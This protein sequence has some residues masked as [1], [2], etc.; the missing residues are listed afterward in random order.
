[1]S[2]AGIIS[3]NSGGGVVDSITATAPLTANGASG[4]PETG[5]VTIALTT[6]LTGAYGGTG[7]ANT[8]LT[9]NLG[10]GSSGYVLTSDSSGNGTWEAASAS[11]IVT[12]DGDSDSVTGTTV[13]ITGGS[14][15]AYFTGSGSTLTE[16]FNYLALPSTTS[17]NGQIIVNG[18]AALHYYE[19]TSANTNLFL[20]FYA[21]N[22]TTT[23]GD[24]TAVGTYALNSLT[25]GGGNTAVGALS[26]QKLTS[27]VR[28]VAIGI[29]SGY[30]YTTSESDNI[31]IGYDV[32][33]TI[34]ESNILR[35]GNGTGVL[36]GEISNAYISGIRGN[37]VSNA[38]LVTVNS[39]TDQ[40]GNIATSNNGVLI[41][42]NSGVPSW[43]ANSG[44]AG[45]VLTAQ[46]GAPPQ[47]AAASGGI[48]TLVADNSGTATGSSVTISGGSTGLTTTAS[49]STM[50][51]TGVL[52]GSNGGTG[53][54]NT[55]L[56]INLGSG[57]S[58]YVLTSDSSGNGTWAPASGGGGST[59]LF[60]GYKSSNSN[61]VTGD[62]TEAYVVWDTASINTGSAYNTS[63]GVFTAPSTGLYTFSGSAAMNVGTFGGNEVIFAFEY[64]NGSINYMNLYS[65]AA[66]VQDANKDVVSPISFSV[67]MNSG[68]TIKFYAQA[69]NGSK[70]VAVLGGALTYNYMGIWKVNSSGSGGPS[71]Y[72]LAYLSSNTSGVTGTG[73]SYTIIYDTVY[74]NHGSAYNSSTGVF[75]APT[76]GLYQISGVVTPGN[77]SSSNTYVL[78]AFTDGGTLAAEFLEIAASQSLLG[79]GKLVLPFSFPLYMSSGNAINL[80]ISV[81][82]SATNNVDIYGGVPD[83]FNN[84]LTFFSAMSVGF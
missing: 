37:S 13:K 3:I 80:V 56:T 14:S 74:V 12:I 51:L 30:S 16:S 29:Q 31:L 27:G 69:V 10:S 41:T 61:N 63:T 81:G 53:V 19:S 6:P 50:D 24:T 23:T 72:F 25:S 39:S 73:N 35:I 38:T 49:S 28:N 7:V 55:G 20:G 76:T 5:A 52:V 78:M 11:G 34:S 36:G 77:L 54:A 70:T 59:P 4:T 45:Y 17:S 79:D 62:G 46:S 32:A 43:L 21:G 71:V 44:T 75:T 58:G 67:Y 60:W 42:S 26:L 33:G 83:A 40:L 9:I 57:S 18:I 8:G 66:A 64:Y 47:W 65:A 48:A 1:M 22:F 2:Q 68:Q 82:G 84:Y 15:G